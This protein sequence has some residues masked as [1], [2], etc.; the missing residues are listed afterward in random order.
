MGQQS[1]V[2]RIVWGNPGPFWSFD[3]RAAGGKESSFDLESELSA[4]CKDGAEAFTI[5][6]CLQKRAT[7]SVVSV[8]QHQYEIE[9]H[10][11]LFI[12]S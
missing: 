6:H 8:S 4:L 3:R 9:A 2:L 12:L 1:L 7:A 11:L 5:V 10:F